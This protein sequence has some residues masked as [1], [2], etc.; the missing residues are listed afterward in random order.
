MHFAMFKNY[1]P[2]AFVIT[3]SDIIL[4]LAALKLF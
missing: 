3:L 4:C 2:H 1:F